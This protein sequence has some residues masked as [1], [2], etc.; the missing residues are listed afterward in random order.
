MKILPSIPRLHRLC[1]DR[2][3]S[4]LLRTRFSSSNLPLSVFLIGKDRNFALISRSFHV[5]PRCHF[6]Q[7]MPFGHNVRAYRLNPTKE[8]LL[9]TIFTIISLPLIFDYENLWRLAKI[10][11]RLAINFDYTALLKEI[12]FP[13]NSPHPPENFWRLDKN[14]KKSESEKVED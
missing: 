12:F 11:Y 13:D 3:V 4:S 9:G 8:I 14:K 5:S 1:S 2:N 6:K 7:K 10:S